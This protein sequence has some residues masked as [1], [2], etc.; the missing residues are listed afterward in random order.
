MMAHK[1]EDRQQRPGAVDVLRGMVGA[2][3]VGDKKSVFETFTSSDKNNPTKSRIPS[4]PG[5]SVY[6][7]LGPWGSTTKRFTYEVQGMVKSFPRSVSGLHDLFKRLFDEDA[8]SEGGESRREAVTA[9]LGFY[10]QDIE[11]IQSLE[12]QRLGESGGASRSK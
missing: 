2:G 5:M 7:L 10:I 11:S 3:R 12:K 4:A 9:A 8:I 1:Q 6:Q